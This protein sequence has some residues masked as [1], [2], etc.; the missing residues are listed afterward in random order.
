[1]VGG[2]RTGHARRQHVRGADWEAE[3]IR[4][5]DRSHRRNLGGSSLSVGEMLL[6]DLFSDCDDDPFPSHHRA[7]AQ[8]HGHGD[9]YPG[10]DEAGGMV[11]VLFV[12]GKRGRVCLR[13][14]WLAAFLREP[15]SLADEI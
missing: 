1:M 8:R 3:T 4:G 13:E 9:L 12:I 11:D 2:H 10:R 7:Q 6:A 5:A 14:L 15:Q